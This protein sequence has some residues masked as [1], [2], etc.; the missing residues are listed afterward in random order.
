MPED[1]GEPEVAPLETVGETQVIDPEEMQHRRVKIVHMHGIL[2]R[3]VA[4]L[5]GGAMGDTS[6]D[7]A[8]AEE[9][10]ERIDVVIPTTAL[11]HGSSSELT[12]KDDQRVLEHSPLLEVHD[13]SRGPLVDQVRGFLKRILDPTVV[14]P[15]AVIQL[16]EANAPLRQS[17]SEEAVRGIGT[18]PRRAPIALQGL[19]RLRR[20]VHEAGNGSL[21]LEGHLILR[22]ASFDLGFVATFPEKP[23]HLAHGF[24]QFLLSVTRDSGRILDVVHGVPLGLELHALVLAGKKSVAPLSRRDGLALATSHAGQ[25]D[26][27]G[28]ILGIASDPVIDPRPHA[29]STRDDGSRVHE[30]MRRVVIDL[31]GLHRTDDGDF[32]G[33]LLDMGEHVADLLS[34]FP[35]LREP[36]L[37]AHAL[38]FVGT[39]LQLGELLSLG[40][41]GGHGLPVE[42]GEFRFVV[43]ALEVGLPP[44]HA[45][46]N[47]SLHLHGNMTSLSQDSAAFP[48]RASDTRGLAGRGM[49]RSG[50]PKNRGQRHRAYARHRVF[51]KGSSFQAIEKF[52]AHT[53]SG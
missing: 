31:L 50:L 44:R 5:V 1:I 15:A 51:E 11:G 32:I 43:E 29:G 26:E 37:G 53:S 17:P 34:R 47:H 12:A 41:G 33:D 52:R 13:Q 3:G 38:E 9:H 48:R 30:G 2:D 27:S 36:E 19:R 42:L 39:L 49:Q 16:D 21:H 24:D 8:S 23:I 45:E 6:L 18:I 4:E 22:D 7:P 14:I 28:Q 40:K 25:N 10:G 46:M 35:T 20:D